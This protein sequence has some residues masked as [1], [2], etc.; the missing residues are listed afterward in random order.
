[1]DDSNDTQMTEAFEGDL[2]LGTILGR[3]Q[4]L[5]M[6]A[7]RCSAAQA[8]CLREI[9]EKKLYKQRCGD[10]D[11]FCRQYLHITR[12]HV[13]HIIDLLNEF[14]PQYFELAQLTRVSPE[15][16]RAIRPSIQDGNLCVEGEAIAL[17]PANAARISAAVAEMRKAA[18]PAPGKAAS[19]APHS[20]KERLAALAERCNQ[21]VAEFGE[22]VR[23][24]RHHEELAALL[25]RTQTGLEKL[26]AEL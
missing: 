22:L 8:A 7:G 11:E 14:G 13:Q 1:M 12:R 10:W 16:Y 17:V 2:A 26:Q 15:T 19:T 6:I 18:R 4:A 21:I 5:G 3:Q 9:Y 25:V 23:H 24:Q 20:T